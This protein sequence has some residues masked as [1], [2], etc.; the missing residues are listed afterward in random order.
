MPA[1][2]LRPVFA[3]PTISVPVR[4][5]RAPRPMA[6]PMRQFAAPMAV[7]IDPQ[8]PSRAS[9]LVAIG[10]LSLALAGLWR[11][12]SVVTVTRVALDGLRSHQVHALDLDAADT[13]AMDPSVARVVDPRARTVALGAA[14]GRQAAVQPFAYEV[15]DGETLQEVAARFGTDVS[16]LL[17]NNGLDAAEQVQAGARLTVLPVRGVLHLVKAGENLRA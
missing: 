7:P 6:V 5:R 12:E 1:L 16:A 15:R 14:R 4:G 8:A 2:R 9:Q 17:W 3:F 13:P 10:V 11:Q